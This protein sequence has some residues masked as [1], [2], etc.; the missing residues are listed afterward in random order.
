MDRI[1][2]AVFV[3]HC[4]C[5]I[6]HRPFHRPHKIQLYRDRQQT[7]D[8][9]SFFGLMICVALA[10]PMVVLNREMWETMNHNNSDNLHRHTVHLLSHHVWAEAVAD[11]AAA[12]DDDC[13]SI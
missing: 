12:D 6:L 2:Y 1:F 3:V 9:A 7:D 4:L 8:V 11:V 13:V 5:N 10:C